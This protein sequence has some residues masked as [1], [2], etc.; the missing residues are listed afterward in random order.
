MTFDPVHEISAGLTIHSEDGEQLGT[1]KEVEGAYLKVDVTLQPDYWLRR[2][3]VLSF[4]NER[5]TMSFAHADLDAHKH[6]TV[7]E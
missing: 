7:E 1:V 3:D 5:V 6:H 4:T 2:S